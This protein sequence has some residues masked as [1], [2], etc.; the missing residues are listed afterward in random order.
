[1]TPKDIQ[2]RHDLEMA[3]A[4]GRA[5]SAWRWGGHGPPKER[6]WHL[7]EESV[8]CL[9]DALLRLEAAIDGPR[10]GPRGGYYWSM[11]AEAARYRADLERLQKWSEEA[12][13]FRASWDR[14]EWGQT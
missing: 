5:F 10:P 12:A 8:R 6:P 3:A 4:M 2:A 11:R 9:E 1:M 13:R 14:G 7:P